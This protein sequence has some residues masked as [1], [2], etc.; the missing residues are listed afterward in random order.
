MHV[1]RIIIS[2]LCFSILFSFGA[3]QD[4]ASERKLETKIAK[5]QDSLHI[6]KTELT[7]GLGELMGYIQL[8]HAKLYFAGED[9]NWPLAKFEVD[10]LQ[11]TFDKAKA[12]ET[13]RP[14]IKYLYMIQPA[15]DS[16]AA[17]V[18]AQNPTQFD[19][20]YHMLT[21]S[22][23]SCHQTVHFAFNKIKTPTQVPYS[24]QDFSPAKNEH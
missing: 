18:K 19:S 9:K 17:S 6:I 21:N 20:S 16:V 3:C 13:D 8:H 12:I 24:N 22:C 1:Y 10:E 2:A 11:E 7:P 15:L 14:E 23:N 4:K 5:L